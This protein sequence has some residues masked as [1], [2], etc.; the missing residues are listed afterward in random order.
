MLILLCSS[1]ALRFRHHRCLAF[2]ACAGT[3]NISVVHA[4]LSPSVQMLLVSRAKVGRTA[5]IATKTSSSVAQRVAICLVMQRSL[6]RWENLGT[7][8]IFVATTATSLLRMLHS[9]L[10]YHR[11]RICANVVNI[12]RL[13]VLASVCHLVTHQSAHTV[14]STTSFYSCLSVV[15][16]VK[17]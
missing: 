1:F 15:H 3:P 4:A 13:M 11:N 12:A 2:W 7:V 9:V 8:I 6:T 10:L 5:R 14:R 16:V 17:P